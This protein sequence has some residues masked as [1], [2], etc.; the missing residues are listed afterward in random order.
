MAAFA[1]I[2]HDL[3]RKTIVLDTADNRQLGGSGGWGRTALVRIYNKYHNIKV[4]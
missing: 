1:L 3:E 4:T 2:V